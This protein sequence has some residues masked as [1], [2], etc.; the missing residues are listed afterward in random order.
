MRSVPDHRLSL[1][2]GTTPSGS[3]FQIYRFSYSIQSLQLSILVSI[4]HFRVASHDISE[5][6]HL[7]CTSYSS[8]YI[9][10]V[11]LFFSF[12]AYDCKNLNDNIRLSTSKIKLFG[13]CW[14]FSE[15]FKCFRGTVTL[16]ISEVS[17][18]TPFYLFA[19]S[20]NFNSLY[21]AVKQHRFGRDS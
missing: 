21:D 1:Q 12:L 13:W 16:K 5:A 9:S 6:I 18:P 14:S 19:S 11:K 2:S 10:Q 17:M 4:L 7:A 3:T 8:P 20:V 15:L